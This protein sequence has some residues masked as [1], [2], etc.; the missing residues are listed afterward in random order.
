LFP[1]PF[2]S[3]IKLVSQLKLLKVLISMAVRGCRTKANQP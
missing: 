1:S 3:G 2:L